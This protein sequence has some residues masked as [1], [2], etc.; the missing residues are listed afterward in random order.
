M[1][2]EF[3]PNQAIANQ[4]S[5]ATPSQDRFCVICQDDIDSNIKEVA[6]KCNHL[7]HK[8]CVNEWLKLKHHC[9]TCKDLQ[10]GIGTPEVSF[11]HMSLTD[12][13]AVQDNNPQA[14]QLGFQELQAIRLHNIMRSL[15]DM[16]ATLYR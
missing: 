8:E 15:S 14:N 2:P 12:I 10:E 9:P 16:L 6:L 5:N 7:F 4:Q 13:L 11:T 3:N 1:I